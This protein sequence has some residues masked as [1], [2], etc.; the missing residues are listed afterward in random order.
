MSLVVN[1]LIVYFIGLIAGGLLGAKVMRLLWLSK[2]P[3]D[4]MTGE[5]ITGIEFDGGNPTI[6]NCKFEDNSTGTLPRAQDLGS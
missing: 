3:E 5:T 6:I 1:M 4:E 2:H